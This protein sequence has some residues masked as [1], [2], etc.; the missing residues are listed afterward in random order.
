MIEILA[1][2]QGWLAVNKPIGLSVHSSSYTGPCTTTLVDQLRQQLGVARVHAVHRLDHATSG[3]LLL[4]LDPRTAAYFTEQFATRR[5]EKRYLAVVRGHTAAE[6]VVDAPLSGRDGR[7]P[8]D[9]RTA[10]VTLGTL[11]VPIA[12]GR[13]LEARYSLVAA[14]PDTGR[15]HQIRRHLKHIAHPI[16]GDV[17]YGKGDHNRL[18]R[19]HFGI[20]R[21]LL[22]AVELRFFATD[23]QWLTVTA[24]LDSPM[25]KACALFDHPSIDAATGAP[26]S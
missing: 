25:T 10:F 24:P 4:A 13:Y 18:F 15:H 26:T 16:V 1:T 14:R 5:V 8:K 9:A 22:H 6:F 11:T 19:G 12:L 20:H 21:L 7:A 23:G 17:K 2:G 3:V